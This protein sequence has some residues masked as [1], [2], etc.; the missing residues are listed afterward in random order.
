MKRKLLKLNVGLKKSLKCNGKYVL[1]ISLVL[2]VPA[3]V[4]AAEDDYLNQLSAEADNTYTQKINK[5]SL[6]A[7]EEKQLSKMEKMLANER[8]T[9][10]KFYKKLTT[11]NKEKVLKVHISKNKLSITSKAI[12]DLYLSN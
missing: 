2:A 3:T 9:T 1:L 8:P 4:V 11:E 7:A 6:D 5:K 12:M 10:Y